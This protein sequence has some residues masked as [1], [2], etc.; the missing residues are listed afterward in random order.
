VCR[1]VHRSEK[2]KDMS[3]STPKPVAKRSKPVKGKE[4]VEKGFKF[5]TS[6]R[7]KMSR[8]HSGKKLSDETKAKISAARQEREA[9]I[10]LGLLPKF[11][12]SEETK[13]HL[14]KVMKRK[15]IKPSK[16]ALRRSA[17]ERGNKRRDKELARKIR[18]G[19]L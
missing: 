14:R 6:T 8:A 15:K 5:K 9:L 1:A 13:E 2:E 10:K 11:K 18:K 4:E 16:A 3:N 19:T 7:K 17:Q 12:H